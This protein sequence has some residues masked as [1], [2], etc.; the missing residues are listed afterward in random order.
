MGHIPLTKMIKLNI[1]QTKEH[2]VVLRKSADSEEIKVGGGEKASRA[3]GE[4]QGWG[5]NS[6][7]LQGFQFWL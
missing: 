1:L 5:R 6:I 4:Q 3:E 2:R 7:V